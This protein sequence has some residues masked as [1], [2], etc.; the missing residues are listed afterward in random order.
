[1]QVSNFNHFEPSA[2]NPFLISFGFWIQKF[3][4]QFTICDTDFAKVL[5]NSNSPRLRRVAS[6][7]GQLA[8][9]IWNVESILRVYSHNSYDVEQFGG[10]LN[11]KLDENQ[12]LQ[13]FETE[14]FSELFK[15]FESQ[16][17]ALSSN[18]KRESRY[19]WPK[20]RGVC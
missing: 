13:R 8:C 15:A 4:S 12:G 20:Q 9:W 17:E 16:F 11:I 7:I 19:D 10:D 1:M 5:T 6:H 18:F 14:L 2:K 3:D